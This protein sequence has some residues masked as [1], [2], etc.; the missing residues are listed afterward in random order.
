[1][2]NP[3]HLR[4]F[5]LF[6]FDLPNHKNAVPKLPEAMATPDSD[7]LRGNPVPLKRL[8]VHYNHGRCAHGGQAADQAVE[9]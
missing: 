8:P 9:G 3:A 1:M 2:R 7:E 4:L 5:D 6:P